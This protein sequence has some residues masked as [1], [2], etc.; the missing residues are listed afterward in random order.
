MC[1]LGNCCEHGN[2]YWVSLSLNT[3]VDSILPK[4]SACYAMMIKP[5]LSQQLLKV[6]Y[7]SYFHSIMSYGVIFWGHV[8][9]T[10]RVF[11]LQKRILRIIT[12]CGM[13]DPCR[14]LFIELK[15]LTFLSLYIYQ[16][17]MF[18]N[19]NSELYITNDSIHNYN[20]RLKKNLHQPVTNLTQYQNGVLCK[21]TKM[22][23]SLPTYIKEASTNTKKFA[24][25]L[26]MF[27]YEKAFYT[28]DEFYTYHCE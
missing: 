13:R 26:K 10:I 25:V 14:K 9:N 7:Y 11:R 20:T 16:L 28:L 5:Y 18:V 6:I 21:G 8:K 15:I 17:I 1:P 24:K 4:L 22:Y 23:N 27:L 12:G 3:H 2:E 19:K